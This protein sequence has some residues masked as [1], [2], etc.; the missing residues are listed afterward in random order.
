MVI[1]HPATEILRLNQVVTSLGSNFGPA[2]SGT[3]IYLQF[4]CPDAGTNLTLSLHCFENLLPLSH[5][6][7]VLTHFVRLHRLNV[8]NVFHLCPLLHADSILLMVVILAFVYR[9]T[10]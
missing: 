7:L 5:P 6:L 2:V 8:K 10:R 4:A 3:P 1:S 9:L